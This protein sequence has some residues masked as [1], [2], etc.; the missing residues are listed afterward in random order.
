[1]G[2]LMIW[3]EY[4]FFPIKNKITIQRKEEYGGNQ[5]FDNLEDLK[6][7]F[8]EEQ[9]HLGDLKNCVV[10][11]L[12]ELLKP[13]RDHLNTPENKKLTLQA[14]PEPKAEPKKKAAPVAQPITPGRMNLRVGHIT[15]C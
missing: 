8:S 10:S 9:V 12:S 13:V 7:A 15:S 4:V 6:K 14:Y 1:M 3:M 5:E 11:M 2:T